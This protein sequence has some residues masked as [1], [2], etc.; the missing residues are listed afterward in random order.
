MTMT[1]TDAFSFGSN[2]D[3]IGLRQDLAASFRLAAMF[4]WHE[5]VANHFSVAVSDD[6]SKFLINPKWRHFS[7]I[8]AS[9]LLLL[10]ATDSETMSRPD[11][12]DETAWAIHSRLHAVNPSARV[13]LHVHSDYATAL[14]C[15]E[16]PEIKPID[17]NT[18]RFYQRVAIDRAYG[19]FADATEE[20]DRI[21]TVLGDHK[22]MIMGNHGVMVIGSSISEAFDRLYYFEKACKTLVLAYS[23]QR[24]LSILDHE[25]A[26]K[27][28]RQWEDIGD[29]HVA[30]FSELKALLDGVD[31]SYIR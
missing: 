28:A 26:E 8:R 20:A 25:V 31:P 19:G 21:A 22:A 17:Q 1:A 12:P 6:G 11:A 5:S 29:F 14:A 30:H 3:N 10:D 9:E 4:N 24:Q 13:I 16:D 27:T 15:L 23:T 7:R 18:C 2:V